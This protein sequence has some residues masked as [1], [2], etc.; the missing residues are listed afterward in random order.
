MDGLKYLNDNFGHSKGDEGLAFI[1]S[2]MQAITRE[3][4][5]CVRNG[6]DEFLIAG[7]GQYS[8]QEIEERLQCFA[9]AIEEY[10]ATSPVAFNASIG[11]CL[12]EWGLPSAFEEAMETADVNMYIDKR[13]KKNRR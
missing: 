12:K 5:V 11:Y 10:N 1:A 3:G 2:S 13:K 6:G 9:R 7:L 8:S 4:E